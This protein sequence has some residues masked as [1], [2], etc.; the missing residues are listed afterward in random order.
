MKVTNVQFL[1]I[2]DLEKNLE[3]SNLNS[4]KTLL[5][6]FSGFIQESELQKIVSIIKNKNSEILFI[7]ST[8]AGEI[9]EGGVYEKSINISI[10]EFDNTT[11]RQDYFI[12][13]DDYNL[14]KLIG[15]SLFKKN[16]KATIL[17]IDAL[18]T[19]GNDLLDGISSIDS[20]IPLAGGLAGDNGYLKATFVF[21]KNG[22]YS[23][24]SVAASL[25]SDT[26]NVF[27]EYQLNWQAIGKTMSVTKAEKN[28]LYEIDGINVS[29]IYKKY[30]GEK[31]GN[32]LPFS[33]T[34]FPLLKIQENDLEICRTFTHQF[35]DGSLL[36]IGNLEAG[37]KVRFAFGN[38]DLILNNTN[39]KI[40]K[41]F[42][43]QPEALFVYSCT[44]RKAFLQS[45]IVSE[46]A[47][48]N[49]IAPN[50]GFFTYGEIYHN[51]NRN[52]L[53]NIS[54]TILG[55]S[56]T[57][58]K[59]IIINDEKDDETN[60][61]NFMANKHYLVLDA[62]T[63]LS[64]SVISELEETKQ[65]LKEQA[66]RDYLTGLY[67]RRYFNEIAQD[68]IHIS[69]RE[70]KPFSV[71]MLDIDKFKKI[72]DTYGHSIGDDVLKA[73]SNIIQKTVR[74]SDIV[75]RYGGEEF[76]LLLPFTDKQGA[77]RIAEKIRINVEDTKIV[78]HNS[79]IVQFT[80]SL[81]VD[82]I[83]MQDE[84]IEESLDRADSALYNAKESGRNKV[85]VN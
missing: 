68:F 59:K 11:I 54:L 5:Q 37:D 12:D 60:E 47:P 79:K 45:Q 40:K 21:D 35:E 39:K 31:I 33:A 50:V 61:K 4:S 78:L 64:N 46:L 14:G 30:L 19:N 63:H 44:S 48:L 29:E 8:T 56:E 38:V 23:K 22:V 9:Y 81:G 71:I 76:A 58:H 24:G 41:A 77:Q 62:L 25:N 3:L 13:E 20:S 69:K 52:S 16:T 80:V 36:M 83:E 66:N 2:D 43:F 73:L 67:N 6:I 42:L 84:N 75:S 70:R 53:L 27:T 10:M 51:N 15:K 72:N 32:N 55:L 18:K 34:E 65:Q 7:G 74:K 26:L 82:C 85:I 28:R 1:S 57:D 17:F 49:K